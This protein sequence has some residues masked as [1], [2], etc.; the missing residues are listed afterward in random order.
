M[1]HEQKISY[2]AL[3]YKVHLKDGRYFYRGRLY[4]KIEEGRLVYTETIKNSLS[5]N[6]DKLVSDYLLLVDI[7]SITIDYYGS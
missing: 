5:R 2:K 1:T 7:K 6:L 3:I 4:K